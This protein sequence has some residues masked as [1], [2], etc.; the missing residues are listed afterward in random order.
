MLFS[1]PLQDIKCGLTSLDIAM[2]A[3]VHLYEATTAYLDDLTGLMPLHRLGR[4]HNSIFINGSYVAVMALKLS[5][6]CD[7]IQWINAD[8]L[9]VLV[10][11]TSLRFSKEWRGPKQRKASS[12]AYSEYLHWLLDRYKRQ[13]TS[14][15]SSAAAASPRDPSRAL[16]MH[17]NNSQHASY[18][19]LSSTSA[20][21]LD[22]SSNDLWGDGTLF[23]ED[24]DFLSWA[25]KYLDE[26]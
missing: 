5:T 17:T 7:K 1:M 21:S 3:I 23:F 10:E 6:L 25:Q 9:F 20:Q 8:Q 14:L 26:Q 12:Q 18:P 4:G 16:P 19:F 11:E 15:S 24:T 2:P 13:R 22:P